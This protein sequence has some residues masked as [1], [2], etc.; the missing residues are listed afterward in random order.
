MAPSTRQSTISV[1]VGFFVFSCFYLKYLSISAILVSVFISDFDANIKMI[2]DIVI[3][4]SPNEE[5]VL[6]KKTFILRSIEGNISL[7]KAQW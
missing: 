7:F 3:N 6:S 2:H 5:H 4:L 1:S